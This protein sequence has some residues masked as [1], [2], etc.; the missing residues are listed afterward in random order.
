MGNH[1]A[2]YVRVSSNNQDCASQ[3]PE[4]RQWAEAQDE[5]VKFYEDHASGKTMNRPA[6]RELEAAM[7]TGAIK[8]IVTWR[9]DRLGRTAS[10][11]TTLFDELRKRKV[12]LISLKDGI[13]LSTSAGVLLAGVL[14]SVSQWEREARG[15]R[16]RA[17]IAAAKAKG[18]RWG[19]SKPGIRRKVKPEMETAIQKLRAAGETVS[20]IARTVGLAR[21]TVRSV[22]KEP[23]YA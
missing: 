5:P 18:K 16:V 3:F 7:R 9:L 2:V 19:G 17:G 13:D 11:L 1:C 23:A 20:A 8:T 21:G 10:G 14:A 22:L 4:L 12:N 15:E 6:W